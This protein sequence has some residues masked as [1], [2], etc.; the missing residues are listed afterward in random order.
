MA[1][2]VDE[3]IAPLVE[4]MN[5]VDFIG[6]ISCCAGHPDE[7]AEDFQYAVANVVFEVKDEPRN[8]FRWYQLMERILRA[9]QTLKVVHDFAC[10]FDK[11]YSLGEE[12]ALSWVWIL[13]VEGGGRDASACRAALD[14]GLAFLAESFQRAWP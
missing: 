3:E 10:T 8:L 6:T 4:A 7:K 11:R 12:G 13:K 2:T 5:G 9:R 1:Q 14:E